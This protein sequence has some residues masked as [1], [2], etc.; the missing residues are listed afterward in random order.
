[1]THCVEGSDALGSK[2]HKRFKVAVMF[3][4]NSEESGKTTA[5]CEDPKKRRDAKFEVRGKQA[6]PRRPGHPRPCQALPVRGI[7]CG[8][9]CERGA[10]FVRGRIRVWEG[11]GSTTKGLMNMCL[12]V[13]KLFNGR[14]CAGLC[15][16]LRNI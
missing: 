9:S 14:N 6:P 11:R 8:D 5:V 10:E 13:K 3:L 1:M 15:I 7:P 2:R 12:D 16:F 4:Q